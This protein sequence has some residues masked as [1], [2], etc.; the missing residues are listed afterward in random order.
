MQ[1]KEIIISA[2]RTFNHP[3]EQYANLKPHITLKAELAEPDDWQEEVKKM[4]AIAEGLI[5]DH[6]QLMLKQIQ[7]LYDLTEKQRE[8]TSLE[9]GMRQAQIRLNEIR[10]EHPQLQ[11]VEAE[12]GQQF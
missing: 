8:V 1:V 10:K 12:D 9:H 3:Y 5:E 4:Q 2:G 11:L 6:K 7:D